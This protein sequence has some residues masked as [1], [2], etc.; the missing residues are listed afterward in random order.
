[1]NLQAFTP[2]TDFASTNAL[3]PAIWESVAY[4]KPET[5]LSALFI[6][7]ILVDIT[8]GKKNKLILPLLTLFGLL[9]TTFFVVEQMTMPAK[10]LFLGMVAL[11][12]FAV[13]FKFLFIAAGILAVVLTMDSDEL[14]SPKVAG[15]GEYYSLVI[16]MTLGMF[17]MASAS[18]LLMMY[19]SLELVSFSSY[20]MTGYLKGQ[21]RSTEAA[22]KYIIYGAV[23]SG[24]MIYGMS[25]LYG[26]TGSTNIYAIH[27][28]L[29]THPTDNITLV[30]SGILI[31]GG[32]GYK[33]GAVPFH[34]WTPDVYEGAPT[35]VTA[36][37][38][39]ASKSAGFA[40]L[41]RFFNVTIPASSDDIKLAFTEFN[42]VSLLALISVASMTIG[43]F[44]A[45]WQSNVK[46][47][48]AYSSIAHAGYILLGV[49]VGGAVGT[50]AVMFY[51]ATYMIMN[52]GAFFVVVLI[53]NKIGSDELSDYKGIGARMPL[54][55][56]ALTIFLVSL[57]GLPPTAG[58]IGKYLLF[59]AMLGKG[60]FYLWLAV[61]AVLNSVVSLYYYFKIPL[62]MYLRQSENPDR[63]P[64]Q[65]GF[66]SNG[67]IAVLMVATVVL[68]IF[69]APLFDLTKN[70]VMIL[71]K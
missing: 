22:L 66:V 64:L 16:A 23:S 67:I 59:A 36:F 57:T 20:V 32:F 30:L 9:A 63:S 28:F 46:R 3:F 62:N 61:I 19:V 5:F 65:F 56:A 15:L 21:V 37:L 50:Q 51:L 4:F 58:F 1:M 47:L 44:T 54:A 60:T 70:S 27:Q 48:L 14:N 35:P 55:A 25:I 8:V 18:D 52:V 69:F 68:G 42:W 53:S 12:A 38:S 17:L 26:L 40:M 39:V 33:I 49:I 45:I 24:L 31:M 13:F 11:D 10:N 34:F 29:T 6:V 43:N 7:A 2:A 71:M 41:I